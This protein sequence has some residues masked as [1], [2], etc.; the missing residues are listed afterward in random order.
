MHF[1]SRLNNLEE[2]IYNLQD[3]L[4]YDVTQIEKYIYRC[5]ND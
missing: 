5:L 4:R 2:R 1:N 3:I